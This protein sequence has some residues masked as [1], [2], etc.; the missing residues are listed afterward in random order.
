MRLRRRNGNCEQHWLPNRALSSEDRGQVLALACLSLPL[1]V[2][3]ANFDVAANMMGVQERGREL[4]IP[5]EGQLIFYTTAQ[6]LHAAMA[7]EG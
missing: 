2:N 1:N 4:K 7:E 3:A 5:A 6:R